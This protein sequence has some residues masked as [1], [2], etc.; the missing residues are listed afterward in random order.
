MKIT[1][2]Q[3]RAINEHRAG[4]PFTKTLEVLAK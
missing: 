3:R 4:P 2:R 1:G